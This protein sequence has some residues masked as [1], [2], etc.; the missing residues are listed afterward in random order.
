MNE[1]KNITTVL[2]D[3]D[4]TIIDF[5]SCSREAM[6]N[7]CRDLG[8]PFDEKFFNTFHEVK[9]SFKTGDAIFDANLYLYNLNSTGTVEFKDIRVVRKENK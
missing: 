5:R 2:L 7:A 4:N 1:M 6:T 8:I 3:V 9:G